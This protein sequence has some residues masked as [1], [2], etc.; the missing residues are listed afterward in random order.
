[1]NGSTVSSAD[2]T[3][4]EGATDTADTRRPDAPTADFD[5]RSPCGGLQRW[6]I[7]WLE[8]DSGLIGAEL[9]AERTMCH[10]RSGHRYGVSGLMG[11][12]WRT[13]ETGLSA[14]AL[15][16]VAWN[17]SASARLIL[18]EVRTESVLRHACASLAEVC[19]ALAR[20]SSDDPHHHRVRSG[21]SSLAL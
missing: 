2:R 6:S 17:L 13:L 21:S 12:T 18:V 3:G 9:W 8:D 19:G 11:I 16:S 5:R 20:V 14:R 4:T 1:M 7:P 10:G 15:A